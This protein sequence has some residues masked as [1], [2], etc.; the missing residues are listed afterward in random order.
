MSSSNRTRATAPSVWST[1]GLRYAA[2]FSLL[3]SLGAAVMVAGVDY[4]LMRF[5]EAEVRDGLSHQMEVMRADA[6]RYGT[7][8]LVHELN[9]ESRNRDA[10]RY[11]LLVEAPGGSTFSNGLTRLAVNCLLYTSDAADD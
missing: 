2:A 4:G 6:D 5:A 8:A 3:F 11:L 7:E 1:T 9:A 10:R